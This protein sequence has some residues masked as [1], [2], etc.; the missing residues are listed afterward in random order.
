MHL[1]R[2]VMH[3]TSV[4]VITSIRFILM[5]LILSLGFWTVFT[6]LGILFDP[7][8]LYHDFVPYILLK[9]NFNAIFT[10]LADEY[11][12]ARCGY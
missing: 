10:V 6:L 12:I 11:S 3:S 8:L 7:D 2:S 9:Y 1:Y 4:C 5:C